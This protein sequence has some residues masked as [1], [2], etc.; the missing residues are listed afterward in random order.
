MITA[1]Q[2]NPFHA[3]KSSKN[4][5]SVFQ[6]I[7]SVIPPK[8]QWDKRPVRKVGF[9]AEAETEHEARLGIVHLAVTHAAKTGENVL[10]LFNPKEEAA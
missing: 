4:V 10:N 9:I 5:V 3:H 7:D 8:N 6:R 2:T 1:R